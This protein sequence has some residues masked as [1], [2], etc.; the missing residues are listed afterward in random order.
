M[1]PVEFEAKGGAPIQPYY[2][3]PWQSEGLEDLE[4]PVLVPLR[5]D[6]FCLPFGSNSEGCEEGK[7]LTHGEAAS[8]KWQLESCETEGAIKTLT[9]GLE[10][11]IR[12]GKITKKISLVEG[13]N[14]IYSSHFL[15]GYSGQMP[16]GHHCTLRVPEE[17]ASLKITVSSFDWG[18]TNPVPFGDPKKG[19]FQSLAIKAK[20][21]DISEVPMLE[22]D[23]PAAD[24]SAFP[25][26]EGFTD[27]IQIQKVSG[28]KPAWTT[29]T[30]QKEGYLWFSLK[31]AALL[32]STVFWIS[33]KG[34]HGAPWSARN[35]CL[36]LEET[37]SY[38]AEG[39]ASSCAS[40]E[41][42]KA[43]FS[44]AVQFSDTQPTA[45]HFIQ[46]AI[47]IP[48]G[49][50]QVKDLHFSQGEVTFVSTTGKEVRAAVDWSFLSGGDLR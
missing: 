35:R 22:A 5:G 32:P 4:E 20:F 24:C 28:D 14:V 13:Q 26:R 36:G 46:G 23:Q 10:T 19:E 12:K 49:F 38:F 21:T 29:A 11:K 41:I 1:A 42:N 33:N 45:I 40:N 50:E 16:L 7:L 15:E 43:G 44:T 48:E 37:C 18:M 31:D 47:R 6:F 8:S 30:C 17:E 27:L 39:T 25:Q 9:L 2:L 34:R 3:S